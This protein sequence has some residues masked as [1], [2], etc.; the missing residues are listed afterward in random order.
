MPGGRGEM[1]N[2]TPD[3][4]LRRVSAA[5]MMAM[6]GEVCLSDSD[7]D[8]VSDASAGFARVTSV[9]ADALDVWLDQVR[10]DLP[11]EELRDA[12]ERVFAAVDEALAPAHAAALAAGAST[13]SADA[14]THATRLVSHD[15]ATGRARLVSLG[16]RAGSAVYVPAVVDALLPGLSSEQL[17]AAVAVA[18]FRAVVD[19]AAFP[20]TLTGRA[21]TFQFRQA[22]S[23]A[24]AAFQ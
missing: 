18:R 20:A 2:V 15:P 21:L 7:D 3:A 14:L 4:V 13:A 6:E 23:A 9:S 1:Q 24:K 19:P 22:A 11:P 5:V 16:R 17:A 10:Q 12:A 8:A